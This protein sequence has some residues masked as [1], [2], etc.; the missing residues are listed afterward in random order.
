VLTT[1]AV[2]T[3]SMVL[4]ELQTFCFFAFPAIVSLH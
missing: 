4:M 3:V 1:S 2:G